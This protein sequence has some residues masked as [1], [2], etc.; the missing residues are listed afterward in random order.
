MINEQVIFNRLPQ[1]YFIQE[2]EPDDVMMAQSQLQHM[3]EGFIN[4]V[5]HFKEADESTEDH[6]QDMLDPTRFI[7]R[8]FGDEGI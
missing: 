3:R 2:D 5:Q 7:Q 8:H 1:N 6:M 4:Y